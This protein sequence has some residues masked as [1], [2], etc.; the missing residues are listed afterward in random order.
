MG[1]AVFNIGWGAMVG[2]MLLINNPIF[3]RKYMDFFAVYGYAM[4]YVAAYLFK[5]AHVDTKDATEKEVL[6]RSIGLSTA[7]IFYATGI[8]KMAGQGKSL[9]ILKGY[10]GFMSI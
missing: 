10:I 4:I 9:P 7:A 8:L 5:T 3:C 6:A 2:Q 1:W